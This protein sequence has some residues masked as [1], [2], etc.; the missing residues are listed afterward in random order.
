M[1]KFKYY[2]ITLHASLTVQYHWWSM[3]QANDN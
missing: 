3:Q 1:V 2:F